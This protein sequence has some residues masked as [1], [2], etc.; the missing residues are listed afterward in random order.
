MAALTRKPI[1]SPNYSSRGG[2]GVRLIVL[3]TAEGALT[4]EEL[5]NFFAS[6]SSGVSSH[7]G[8][9]DTAGVVGEYVKR[10]NKA[11]TAGN[12]NPVA[13]QAELCAFAK[14]SP[15]EWQR[16][17]AMLDNTA[18]WI[19]EEAAYFGIP[20]T[21]LSAAEAQGSGRGVCQ[22]NDLGSWGGGHWDCGGGFPIDQ[23]LDTARGGGDDEMGYPAWFWDWSN[24]YLTTDRDDDDR[25]DTAP[26]QIP[27]WAWDGLDEIQTIGKRY[28]MTGDERDWL[29]WYLDGKQGA[30]PDVPDTIPDR[31]WA[32]ERWAVARE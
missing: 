15:D 30:R 31:W 17:P 24:W 29:D 12:A 3:H 7:T 14:W 28:G 23:V 2:A 6:T 20:I 32:D 27:E 19:A 5:G 8:I 16:H 11:W 4:I 25:P 26:D 10:P 22:H 13:V 1:P 18:R 21:K 9:D